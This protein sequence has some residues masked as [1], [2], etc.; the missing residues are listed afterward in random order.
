MSLLLN[1]INLANALARVT[2]KAIR[3]DALIV[4]V[5]RT[6][7]WLFCVDFGYA[8][9]RRNPCRIDR[10]W[11]MVRYWRKAHVRISGFYHT[12]MTDGM[13]ME[14]VKGDDGNFCT[15]WSPWQMRADVVQY[16]GHRQVHRGYIYR[17]CRKTVLPS[18]CSCASFLGTTCKAHP[19]RDFL[20]SSRA[21]MKAYLRSLDT[22]S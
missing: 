1:S 18:C 9:M 20:P 6:E 8:G 16:T 4:T 14:Y 3:P 15:V 7:R 21:E 13:N 17:D 2:D 22:P 11:E 19:P 5:W 10:P 12:P